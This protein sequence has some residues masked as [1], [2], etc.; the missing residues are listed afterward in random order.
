MKITIERPK[1][2]NI[3][4]NGHLKKARKFVQKQKYTNSRK[5]HTLRACCV[6]SMTGNSRTF[7]RS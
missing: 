5:R 4:Q 2:N 1:D 6:I 7:V 3:S